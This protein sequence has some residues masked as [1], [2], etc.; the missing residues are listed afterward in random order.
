[1]RAF[2][3][4]S[5][6]SCDPDR[7]EHASTGR[8]PSLPFAHLN[9]RCNPFGELEPSLRAELAVVEV[10]PWV[11]RLKRPGYAV[12]FV[13][14]RGRG[15]TTHLL[16][17]GRHFPDA[18]YVHVGEGERPRIPR[19][20][21]LLIDE[22]QRL[23]PRRR[24]RVFRRRVSL[25]IGSHQ[26]VRAELV[27]AGFD[28]ETVDVGGL[29][30]ARRLR[31]ILSRRIEAARRR[32]GPIPQITSPTAHAL[33]DRFGDDLRAIEWHLYDLFQNLPGIQDVEM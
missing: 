25:A 7:P 27:A 19:G 31:E 24:R 1:M 5:E 12:Q 14:D 22:I 20:H 30:D 28:V 3:T 26:D 17:I 9:L 21:P 16:A 4:V 32:P 10:A 8:A 33:I 15:K 29:V 13:G 11:R 2:A 23:P 18:V 6:P